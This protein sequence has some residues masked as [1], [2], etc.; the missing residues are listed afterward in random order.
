MF[1]FICQGNIEII[2]FFK[3]SNIKKIRYK[4]GGGF[5]ARI[6]PERFSDCK[7]F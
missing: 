7:P 3:I 2:F 5:Y 6:K 1:K 4:L